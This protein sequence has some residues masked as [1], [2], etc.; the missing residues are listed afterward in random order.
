LTSGLAYERI[1]DQSTPLQNVFEI[2]V[3]GAAEPGLCP[4]LWNTP[5]RMHGLNASF[6]RSA[7][8]DADAELLWFS[9]IEDRRRGRV[10]LLE[11]LFHQ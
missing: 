1:G 2:W 3:S 5:M 4:G 10:C 8:I 7:A 11:P 9:Q 6:L